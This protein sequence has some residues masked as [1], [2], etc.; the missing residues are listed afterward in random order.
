MSAR[1]LSWLDKLGNAGLL[2]TDSEEDCLRKTI[3]AYSASLIIVLAIFW[4]VV[5]SLLGLWLSAAIPLAYQIISIAT[6]F[7]FARTKQY[8]AF[9]FV[10][11]LMM[12]VLPVLL[13]WSLGGYVASSGVILWSLTAPLGALLFHGTRQSIPWF[14]AYLFLAAASGAADGFLAQNAAPIPT[15]LVIVFFVMNL[16]GVSTT[17]YLLTQYFARRREEALA[18]LRIEQA[19]SERLLLNVLPPSIAQR[20]KQNPGV[21]AD[22]FD[23]VSILF[24][25]VVG[26]TTI[27]EHVPPEEIVPWLNE[28]FSD[29]DRLAARY[30]LE[31]I[32][33]IGDS[34]MAVA[35]VPLPHP[36]H[37]GAVAEMALDM[38]AAAA[39]RKAPNGEPL[40]IRVGINTGHTVGAVIGLDKFIYDVYGDAVNTASRMESHGL[41]DHIQVTE[42]FYLRLKERYVF[43]ERHTVQVKGK[44]E[45]MTYLLTGRKSVQ[46][47][48]VE[49]TPLS[50]HA[51]SAVP[52]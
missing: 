43:E 52:A 10:Q 30:G 24:A 29:F 2:P 45:M 26:F 41:P 40:H 5:Y 18:A 37:A 28:V 49:E 50:V 23:E 33:T 13:Q 17:V 12:L 9:R 8:V 25:D 48:Q 39:G 44:G 11:L 6:L 32:R 34:Y 47:M 36:D 14:L 3:L 38:L 1:L 20:L 16:A 21:I 35:G 19:R 7:R 31:K 4:V 46:P 51:G 22:A 27:S 42:A 15:P